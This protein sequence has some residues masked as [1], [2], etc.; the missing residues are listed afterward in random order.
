[1]ALLTTA[2]YYTSGLLSSSA[3]SQESIPGA[4]LSHWYLP[5]AMVNNIQRWGRV[6]GAT[7]S[8]EIRFS[9]SAWIRI[10][11]TCSCLAPNGLSRDFLCRHQPLPRLFQQF[12]RLRGENTDTG[13]EKRLCPIYLRHAGKIHSNYHLRA[14]IH[15]GWDSCGHLLVSLLLMCTNYS[16]C[17]DIK[18]SQNPA[19]IMNT[20]NIEG[21]VKTA[22]ITSFSV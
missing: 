7:F 1:M 9:D 11:G 20:L 15:D 19:Y 17:A 8:Q 14:C 2:R 3:S 18:K 6:S 10:T 5:A 21:T 16:L 22:K 13:R 12:L 4:V